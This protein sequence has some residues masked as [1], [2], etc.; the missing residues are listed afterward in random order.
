RAG[1]AWETMPR[2]SELELAPA[3]A[4]AVIVSRL[5]PP[6]KDRATLTR[7]RCPHHPQ[8][9]PRGPPVDAAH[10]VSCPAS[11]PACP[12]AIGHGAASG[13]AAPC[14]APSRAMEVAVIEGP[15]LVDR[16]L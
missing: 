5:I 3:A 4:F 16:E 13:L 7:G 2:R 12:R 14:R 11:P 10:R 8:L 15:F 1:A 9:R 6:G